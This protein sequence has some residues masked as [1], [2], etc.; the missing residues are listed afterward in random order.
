MSLSLL[1]LILIINS[2]YARLAPLHSSN[3]DIKG[4]YIIVFK[5]DIADNVFQNQITNA[6]TGLYGEK[7]KHVY[8]YALKGYS[9]ELTQDQLFQIR[10][11]PFVDYVEGDQVVT[12]T[13]CS[14]QPADS[15]GQTRISQSNILLNGA[16]SASDAQGQ[17]VSAF[18]MD[19]GIFLEH[20]EFQGR[21]SNGWKAEE[22]W[23]YADRNGHGTHVSSTIGGKL[24]GVA[25]KIELINVKVLGTDGSGTWSGVIGGIDYI[26]ATYT[27]NKKPSVVNLSLGGG[28]IQSVND[29]VDAAVNAGVTMVVAAGNSNLD[30]CSSSPASAPLAFTV[31]SSDIGNLDGVQK[32]IR[33]TFS[34]FGRCV[35][36]FAPGSDIKA[37][38]IGATDATNIISGTSMASPHV[39]GIAALLLGDAPDQTPSQIKDTMTGVSN[40]NKLDLLC[41][42]KVGCSAS[43]NLLAFNG[44]LSQ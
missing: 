33:S 3:S 14:S 19:T 30:A 41:G 31:G 4:Q 35:D 44:C 24:Y 20:T 37:A 5:K 6:K 13:G 10:K 40:S 1:C 17:G 9:A 32:D 8:Q 34:N 43:P 21:A 29:A 25:K 15:W 12:A 27:A 28:K 23:D 38:W 18:V 36:V 22:S 42:S 26:I 7:I 39:V 11:N 16:Y 2:I